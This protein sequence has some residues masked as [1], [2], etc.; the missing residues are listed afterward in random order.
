MKRNSMTRNSWTYQFLSLLVAWTL[1][2]GIMIDDH[3]RAQSGESG[4]G[5]RRDDT[6]HAVKRNNISADLLDIA[7]R[8]N[9]GDKRVRVI[10]QLSDTGGK[11][12]LESPVKDFPIKVHHKFANLR[13]FAL[14]LPVK[15]V[16]QLAENSYVEY[17][18]LDRE[19]KSLGHV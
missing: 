1:V 2:A 14:E 11:N 7:D 12:D 13:A 18:S 4:K 9:S 3:T 10:L 5:S 19:V 16:K 8:R 17:L 15:A 6:T